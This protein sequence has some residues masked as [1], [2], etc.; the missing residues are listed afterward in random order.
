M[1]S[2]H[3]KNK[4]SSRGSQAPASQTGHISTPGQQR[5]AGPTTNVSTPSTESPGNG[6]P[7]PGVAGEM[8]EASIFDQSTSSREEVRPPSP[9]KEA[10]A[11]QPTERQLQ[12]PSQAE[13]EASRRRRVREI[14]YMPF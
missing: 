2:D 11:P 9:A 14:E 6:P 3:Q 10:P 5:A 8:N 4:A 1:E 7:T 12:Q 13:V